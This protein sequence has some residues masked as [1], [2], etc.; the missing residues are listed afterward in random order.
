MGKLCIVALA[1]VALGAI[2]GIAD[3]AP[4]SGATSTT[5]CVDFNNN[6]VCE[7]G[8][9]PLAP[10][11][12]DGVFSTDGAG[13]RTSGPIGVVV[14]NLKLR[15]GATIVASGDVRVTGRMHAG[16]SDETV[17]V[18]AD[19]DI[20]VAPGAAIRGGSLVRLLPRGGGDITIGAGAR[21]SATG[22]LAVLQL[23]AHDIAIGEDARLTAS[24]YKS[25]TQIEA[26]GA[27]TVGAGVT[28]ASAGWST[29]ITGHSDITLPGAKLAGPDV[30]VRALAAPGSPARH[31]RLAN[32]SVKVGPDD[33]VAHLHLHADPGTGGAG[34]VVLDHVKVNPADTRIDAFPAASI[35]P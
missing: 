35:I 33:G 18:W 17:S 2:T 32:S 14:G 25:R 29:S 30:S 8:D 19:G 22:D 4:R 9:A 13:L 5:S 21:I 15:N 20:V 11:L 23:H 3:A 28:I 12:E 16:G 7:E 34:S 24:G 31:V 1:A 27:L 6:G 26:A 10:E